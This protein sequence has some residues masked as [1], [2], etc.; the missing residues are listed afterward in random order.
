MVKESELF[1][2]QRIIEIFDEKKIR[3]IDF[4]NETGYSEKNLSNLLTGKVKKTSPEF[5]VAF[6]QIFP[7]INLRWLFLGEGNKYLTHKE[8]A[9]ARDVSPDEKT[10][11]LTIIGEKDVELRNSKSIM[12]AAFD[13]LTEVAK[14]LE[15]LPIIQENAQEWASL[16]EAFNAG[17]R[18]LKNG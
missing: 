3:Q 4:C 13:S 1:V 2:N 16:R 6:A 15:R 10:K 9:V 8:L 17:L 12:K 14:T 18:K 11:L 5:F 7:D